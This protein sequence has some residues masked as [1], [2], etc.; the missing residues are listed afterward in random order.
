MRRAALA[1]PRGALPHRHSE[2]HGRACPHEATFTRA[3]YLH[4]LGRAQALRPRDDI[5]DLGAGM[6]VNAGA[7]RLLRREHSLPVARGISREVVYSAGET[8]FV[9]VASGAAQI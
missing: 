5:P 4:A 8:V 6:T 9:R 2:H 3:N 1:P 7:H